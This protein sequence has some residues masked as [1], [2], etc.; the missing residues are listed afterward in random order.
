MSIHLSDQGEEA[1]KFT[2]YRAQWKSNCLGGINA[3]LL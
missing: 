1:G 2:I 3:K